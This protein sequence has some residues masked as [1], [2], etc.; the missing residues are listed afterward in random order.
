MAK[1]KAKKTV[2][3]IS[4]AEQALAS[5]VASEAAIEDLNEREVQPTPSRIAGFRGIC[6]QHPVFI[7]QHM[8]TKIVEID[9]HLAKR[10]GVE[11]RSALPKRFRYR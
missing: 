9:R 4:K 3:T 2:A 5:E 8:A 11:V 10:P 7:V 6:D 1:K